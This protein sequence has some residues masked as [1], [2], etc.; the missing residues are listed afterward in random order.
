MTPFAVEWPPEI[1]SSLAAIWL[2]APDRQAVTDAQQR[3]DDLLSRNPLGNGR[4]LSEGLYRLDVRP[5]AVVY[6]VDSG[7]R[8]VKIESIGE[9]A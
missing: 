7:R 8:H 4:H 1:L 9:L 3:I 6:S 5:L 2:R